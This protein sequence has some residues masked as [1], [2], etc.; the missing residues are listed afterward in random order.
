MDRPIGL[1][2]ALPQETAA[3]RQEGLYGVLAGR[4]IEL[5]T[6]GM[7]AVRAAAAASELLSARRCWMLISF[8]FAAGLR[9]GLGPA[10]T[11][12]L[13]GVVG[14]NSRLAAGLVM[15][16]VADFTGLC[17][18]LAGPLTTAAAKRA[19]GARS[20]A[21]VADLETA[22]VAGVAVAAGV[23][24]AGLRAVTDPVELDL[25]APVLAG[26]GEGAFNL[27]AFAVSASVR[28]WSWPAI[29]RLARYSRT[30][31]A[32][33]AGALAACLEGLP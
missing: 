6:A 26:L 24:W 7:G 21:L 32:K 2:A 3:L 8:G 17:L 30:A 15:P 31:A 16:E 12:A 33:L 27:A 13:T 18:D 5:V 20:G 11:V 28:P 4:R 22:A 14:P 10:Q 1:I 29:A 25:P 19:A 23:P 9:S